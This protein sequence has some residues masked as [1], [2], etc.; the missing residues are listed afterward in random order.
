MV[1][2]GAQLTG[3]TVREFTIPDTCLTYKVFKKIGV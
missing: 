2:D 1:F 3:N